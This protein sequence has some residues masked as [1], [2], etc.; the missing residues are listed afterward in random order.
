MLLKSKDVQ[1][2]C[3]LLQPVFRHWNTKIFLFLFFPVI[4]IYSDLQCFMCLPFGKGVHMQQHYSFNI[5]AYL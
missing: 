2:P 3:V 5:L 4:D 1:Q